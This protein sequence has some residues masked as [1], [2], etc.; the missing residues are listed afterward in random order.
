[1]CDSP[2]T[3]TD[4]HLAY[5]HSVIEKALKRKGKSINK[6]LMQFLMDNE[7]ALDCKVAL[8]NAL[9]W[10][11]DGQKNAPLFLKFLVKNNICKN[12]AD[13]LSSKNAELLICYAYLM[14]MDNY[15]EVSK[16]KQ[17]AQLAAGINKSSYTVQIIAAL[18]A[19][20]ESLNTDWCQVY[21]A[22]NQ[23]REA[24]GLAMDMNQGAVQIIFEY[25]DIYSSSC[26][27]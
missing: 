16:A 25:M 15:F 11:F 22:T 7:G 13:L 5:K 26:D 10:D 2:L 3:S 14:A 12:E 9:G 27:K 1:M 24:A 17:I 23:V 20:Q 21:Q 6:V 8:I 18:I 19:A 4:F